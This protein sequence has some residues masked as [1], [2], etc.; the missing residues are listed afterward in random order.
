ML[1]TAIAAA[2]LMIG[3]SGSSDVGWG[4]APGKARS[5]AVEG[6]EGDVGWGV[7]PV[8]KTA[9][10]VQQSDGDVGWG[11]VGADVTA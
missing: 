1:A 8:G 4:P 6:A 5:V 9:T 2:A 11:S 10:A 3:I 7:A